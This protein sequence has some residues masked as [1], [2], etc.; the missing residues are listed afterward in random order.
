MQQVVIFTKRK[1]Y[2]LV[3]DRCS[4]GET[5]DESGLT[6]MQLIRTRLNVINFE[7]H[8]IPDDLHKIK[9]NTKKYNALNK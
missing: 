7:Y 4:T 9:V 8:I 5:K 2:I 6:L 3:S 1:K